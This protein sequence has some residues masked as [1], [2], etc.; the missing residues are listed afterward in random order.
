M[1]HK[2]YAALKGAKT[3]GRLY[4]EELLWQNRDSVNGFVLNVVGGTRAYRN[5][6]QRMVSIDRSVD[7]DADVICD[8]MNGGLPFRSGTFH[9][10]ICTSVLEHLVDPGYATG[11]IARVLVSN[12]ALIYF[13]PFLHKY[14]AD[15]HD[16]WR[17]TK[18][19]VARILH[20]FE[21]VTLVPVGG[22]LSLVLHIMRSSR[23]LAPASG[24]LFP[25]VRKLERH[26]HDNEDWALG[27]FAVARKR[28]DDIGR[29]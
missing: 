9:A 13:T 5:L 4:F 12:G 14:H 20:S 8:L 2:L 22:K 19:G 3:P 1:F 29:L 7:A 11:E 15:P 17:F 25:V 10:V 16:Y 23:W 6:T 27:F 26:F 24:I 28:D 18:E 21:I